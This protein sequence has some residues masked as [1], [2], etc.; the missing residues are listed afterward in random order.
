VINP[1]PLP[2]QVYYTGRDLIDYLFIWPETVGVCGPV[3]YSANEYLDSNPLSN[4]S[5]DAGVFF[6]P[7]PGGENNTLRIYTWDDSKAG[8]YKVR[9]WASLGV[10]G[11]Q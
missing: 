3:T 1:V 8:S 10:G 9:I 2:S 11:F 7:K 6:Y 5:L 4:N